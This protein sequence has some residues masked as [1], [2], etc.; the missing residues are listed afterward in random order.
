M[1]VATAAA[2][3]V[4]CAFVGKRVLRRRRRRDVKCLIFDIDDT[5]YPVTNGFT[6]HRNLDVALQY[7]VDH[8]GFASKEE[9]AALRTPYFVKFHSTIKALTVAAS[10]GKLP[11]LPGG[12]ARTFD[13]DAL[14]NYWADGCNFADYFPEPDPALV[15]AMTSLKKDVPGLAMVAFTNGPRVYALRL[16]ETLGLSEVFPPED[17]F[18]VD[19]VMPA[20]KPERAAF[21]KVLAAVRAKTTGA[22]AAAGANDDDDDD[23]DDD[24]TYEH[25][26]MFEDSMKN[27][28]AAKALGM[29]TCLVLAKEGQHDSNNAADAGDSGDPAVDLTLRFANQ[30][31]EKA[32]FLWQRRWVD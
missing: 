16:L 3:A 14:A 31:R 27:V 24:L 21:D 30:L 19:D 2:A 4:V 9:A 25:C 13:S 18:A 10:E 15:E 20:C 32:P 17:V 1:T 26:V 12:E 6:A 7:M 11:R 5:L 8:L 29:G 28:R 23:D 22:G